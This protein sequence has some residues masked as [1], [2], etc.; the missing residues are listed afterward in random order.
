MRVN[1][2]YRRAD[3]SGKKR[4]THKNTLIA[5]SSRYIHYLGP[6]TSGSTHDYQLPKK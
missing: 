1:E 5:G 2:Y 4:L 3:Y 6:T